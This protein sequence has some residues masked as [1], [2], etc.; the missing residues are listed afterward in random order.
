M[1]LWE[2]AT[3][4]EVKK[5]A[6]TV[7]L[8]LEGKAREAV[9][10]MDIKTLNENDGMTK[11]YEKL[12]TLFKEDSDQSALLAYEAFEKYQ[13]P[14]GLSVCDY[15]IEFDCLVAKLKDFKITVPEPILA[16]RVLKSA[17]LKPEDER[18]IKA[19]VSE[20]TLAKMS[21]QLKKVMRGYDTSEKKYPAVQVK[22][23]LDIEFNESSSEKQNDQEKTD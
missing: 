13:K 18:L 16:Y 11:L 17:N 3:S 15:L 23:E 10:K 7:F 9:L 12:D 5:R 19:T 2:M 21:E 4:I 8:T 14:E 22:N 1:E 6:P 20:L